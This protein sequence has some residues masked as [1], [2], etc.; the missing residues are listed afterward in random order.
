[1]IDERS[2]RMRTER[3]NCPSPSALWQYESKALTTHFF[4]GCIDGTMRLHLVRPNEGA[5]DRRGSPG[6][7]STRLKR[8]PGGGG[9]WDIVCVPPS[10]ETSATTRPGQRGTVDIAAYDATSLLA[11]AWLGHSSRVGQFGV[12][13]HGTASDTPCATAA[14][15]CTHDECWSSRRRT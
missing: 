11:C 14:I 15:V 12:C 8:P 7:R 1:M 13:L 2:I 3:W 9:A 4:E 5:G 6:G 10:G